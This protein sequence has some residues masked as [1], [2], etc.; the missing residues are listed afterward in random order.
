[1]KE[2]KVIQESEKAKKK[3]IN[4][5][6]EARFMIIA[7]LSI[8]IFSI[9]LTPV[10]LQNDTFYTIKI[11]EHIKNYGI[12][13][14]EPFSWHEGLPYTYPHWLYDLITYNI[15][16]FWGMQGIYIVTCIL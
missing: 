13:M 9:A 3:K 12:D 14:K 16:E 10:T 5:S 1:M 15:Y 2:K 4:I 7:I 8:I 11:G 6:K